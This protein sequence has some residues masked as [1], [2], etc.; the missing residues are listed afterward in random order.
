MDHD[1]KS[2]R[3][4]RRR[5]ELAAAG[6]CVFCKAPAKPERQRCQKCTEKAAL[7][8]RQRRLGKKTAGVKDPIAQEERLNRA[9]ELHRAGADYAAVA[10][11]IGVS[12]TTAAKIIAPHRICANRPRCQNPAPPRKRLCGD[13]NSRDDSFP[14][15]SARVIA[16]Y[17]QGREPKEIAAITGFTGYR[18]ARSLSPETGGPGRLCKDRPVC[19][20]PVAPMGRLCETCR[21]KGRAKGDSRPVPPG[22]EDP[23]ETAPGTAP[24]TAETPQ[25][26]V[27]F[28]RLARYRAAQ[29]PRCGSSGMRVEDGA[30]TCIAC[31]RTYPI[32]EDCP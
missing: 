4:K 12:M 3:E 21:E 25:A 19:Q 32:E 2:E 31:T 16:L 10:A 24:G 18:I 17:R 7:Y 9:M 1:K 5:A 11:A 28:E 13:C 14:E 6:L 22:P 30:A 29:C 20:N 23:K 8:V 27:D 26:P 15:D